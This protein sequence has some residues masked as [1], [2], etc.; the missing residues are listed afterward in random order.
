VSLPTL[1]RC[2]LAEPFSSFSAFLIST[3]AGGVFSTKVKDL[4]A[5]AVMTTGRT[6]PGSMPCVCALKALQNSMMLSPRWP[7]AGPIGGEGFAL[8][9]GTCNLMKPTIFFAMNGSFF[10]VQ[11]PCR[12][13]AQLLVQ[14]PGKTNGG[15]RRVAPVFRRGSDLFD[16]REIELDRRRAAED[17][18]RDAYL[19][20]V[21]VDVFH[22]AVEIG[23]RAFLD[24]HHLAHFPLHLGSRLFN[25]FLHL[26][27]DLHHLGFSD[28]RRPRLRT[29]DEARHPAP[30]L[31]KVPG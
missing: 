1:S 19:G 20:L 11:A 25:A 31:D 6:R 13:P 27:D 8:P 21:V 16:L 12:K 10:R 28:R 22:R 26:R 7:S 18:D 30:V 29:A 15:R 2:G 5:N 17:R 24:A 14:S 3:D 9:A 4:S 23:E